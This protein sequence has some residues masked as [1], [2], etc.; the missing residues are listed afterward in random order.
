VVSKYFVVRD[1]AKSSEAVNTLSLSVVESMVDEALHNGDRDT[2]TMLLPQTLHLGRP[3]VRLVEKAI[4]KYTD[5]KQFHSAISILERCDPY[6]IALSHSLCSD[7]VVGAVNFLRWHEA[8]IATLYMIIHDM[9]FSDRVVYFTVAGLMSESDG[10]Y[11]ML[12]LMSLIMNRRR[13]DLGNIFNFGK[14]WIYLNYIS[15]ISHMY[16]QLC[17]R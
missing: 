12:D 14:V 3:G 9:K 2:L 7:L 15:V 6:K 16:V 4:R 10:L 17:Y 1:D 11:K 5:Q 13:D 8:F